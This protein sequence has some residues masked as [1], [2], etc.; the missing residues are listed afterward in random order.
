[1]ALLGELVKTGMKFRKKLSMVQFSAAEIQMH[2]LLYLLRMA[3][4]TEFG[5]KYKFDEMI[6]QADISPS[7][8]K[9]AYQIYKNTVPIF[10]YNKIYTEWWHQSLDAKENIC[11]PGKVKYF[12]LSSGTS[13]SASKRIPLTKDMIK[14]LRRTSLEQLTSMIHFEEIPPDSFTKPWLLL[15][16]STDLHK[17][18]NYYE[19]DLSGIG[20]KNL[21]F[22]FQ[23]FYK[24]GK[25]ISQIKVWDE[26][27]DEIILHAQNWDIGFIVG[28]PAW[29]QI[30]LEKII[31]HY[32]I[33]HIHELWPN[34][35]VY[36][37]SGVSVEPYRKN[38]NKLFGKPVTFI[39]TYLASEGFIAYQKYPDKGMQLS[40]NGS[41]FFEF[42]PFNS[43][44]FDSDGEILPT[45]KSYMIGEIEE[46]IDYAIL[47]S[48]CAGT[49]RYL[50]GDTIRFT[51]KETQEIIITGRTKHF[52][53]LCGEHLS[54]ENMS[55]AVEMLSK[56]LNIIVQ[57]FTVTG[58]AHGSL[59]AHQWYLG[60]SSKEYSDQ[61]LAQKIDEYLC[62]LNDDYKVERASALKEICVKTYPPTVFYD[63]MKKYGKYGAQAKFPRVLNK[64]LHEKW[65]EFTDC[66]EI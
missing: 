40:L 63:W 59:F 15:G 1:M 61:I 35:A 52:L 19:G 45:C 53:S 64:D 22:W 2:Q 42:V 43:E 60:T 55:K 25:K 9:V 3:R 5:M 66:I 54:V 12:A 50:I 21:P 32:K 37:Y 14:S 18:G 51:N 20:A 38:L 27:I 23:R 30:L 11:W 28:V 8:V 16:G 47:L 26:K 39:E 33:A 58:I 24:P 31:A 34:L 44:N 65:K 62:E 36:T 7:D 41:I 46:G 29:I 6:Y 57:E 13:E 17:K 48:T 56:E 10:N 4:S 49:W